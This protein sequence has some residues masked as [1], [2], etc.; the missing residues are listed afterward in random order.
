MKNKQGKKKGKNRKVTPP[1]NLANK[2]KKK[3]EKTLN[4]NKQK[5][6]KQKR[7]SSSP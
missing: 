1:L 3:K 4:S 6:T 2:K 5:K 7:G